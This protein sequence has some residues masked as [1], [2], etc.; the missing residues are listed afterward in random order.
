LKP[1]VLVATTSRWPPTARL[2]VALANAGFNVEAVC[3]PRHPLMTTKAA[4]RPYIYRGLAPL[5]SFKEAIRATKP[6]LIVPGDDLATQHLHGLYRREQDKGE[7]G[8]KLMALIEKS[9]GSPASFPIVYARTPF[10]EMAHS[11]GVRV[12]ATQVIANIAELTTCCARIG[13]PMVLKANGTSGGDGVRIVHTAQ[14]AESAFRTLHAPPLLARAAKRALAD[15]DRTLLWPSLLRRRSAVNAQTYIAGHEATSLVAC[16][17]GEVLAALHLEV[18]NKQHWAGP[19]TVLRLIEGVEMQAA[20]EKT[21]RRLGLSGL[22][23]FDFMLE[24]GSGDAYL[25]E[26]NPRAT[27]VGHLTL[28]PGRDLPAALY[29]AVTGKIVQDAPRIT[30]K[31]IIALFPQEWTRDPASPILEIAYHDVPWDE[32]EL[33]Q[34]CVRGR[35]KGVPRNFEPTKSIHTFSEPSVHRL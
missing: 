4:P 8:S 1:T 12:P 23:G 2:A 34:A 29:A 18:L 15:H 22:H 27:Q 3:P 6:D 19:A 25:L 33:I 7:S 24:A 31:D 10:M 9:L 5:L 26:V 14:E 20:A 21:V 11:E 13:F 30:D 35:K 32:P 16:W 17:K 28:G